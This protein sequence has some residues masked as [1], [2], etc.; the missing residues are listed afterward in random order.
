[1]TYPDGEVYVGEMARGMEGW[2]DAY[3]SAQ[4]SPNIFQSNRTWCPFN[5]YIASTKDVALAVFYNISSPFTE[6]DGEVV[7]ITPQAFIEQDLISLLFS[8]KHIIFLLVYKFYRS[9]YLLIAKR[10]SQFRFDVSL[11]SLTSISTTSD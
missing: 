6:G 8:P 2:Q 1:M 4:T 10:W 7:I 9:T 3:A 11:A 5:F